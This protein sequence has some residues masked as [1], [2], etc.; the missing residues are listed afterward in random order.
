MPTHRNEYLSF[1][2]TAYLTKPVQPAELLATLRRVAA[3][4]PSPEERIPVDAAGSPSLLDRVQVMAVREAMGEEAWGIAVVTFRGNAR[5][6]V[7]AIRKAAQP[8]IADEASKRAC[9]HAL[10]GA[11]GSMGASR[12]AELAAAIETAPLGETA[13]A[14]VG[15]DELLERTLAALSAFADDA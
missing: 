11:A 3:H 1:G 13:K 5:D 9:A 14:L 7:E 6:L 2:M 8:E 15:I 4:A 12:L 10:K